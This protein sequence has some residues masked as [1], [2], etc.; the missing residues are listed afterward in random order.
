MYWPLCMSMTAHMAAIPGSGSK[1]FQYLPRQ[2]GKTAARSK[3]KSAGCMKSMPIIK[4]LASS[5]QSVRGCFAQ[6]SQEDRPAQA[7]HGPE[8]G[9]LFQ[10]EMGVLRPDKEIG[11]KKQNQKA[12]KE[13]FP[14]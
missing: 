14:E 9:Y 13:S 10:A 12:E 2:K 3:K 11:Q 7:E 4:V 5:E 6:N 8:A 1:N